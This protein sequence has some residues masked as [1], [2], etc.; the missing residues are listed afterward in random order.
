MSKLAKA[1]TAAAG[2]AGVAD[3]PNVADVFSTYLYEGTGSGNANT[4]TNG[5]DLD[6]EGGMVW[7][8]GRDYGIGNNCLFD[9]ERGVNKVLY[10]NS[11]SA[12]GSG[13]SL[14]SFT[15]S[16]FVAQYTNDI[17]EN[18]RSL[19]SW[20]FR[21]APR[22][23]DVVTYTGDGVTGREIAHDLGCDVG[24]IFIKLR[25]ELSGN[26]GSWRT[27]HKSL[28]GTQ[29]LLLE[30]TAAASTW[31]GIFNDTDATDSVFTVTGHTHVNALGGEYVAY[32]FAHDPDGENDDGMIACGSFVPSSTWGSEI[33]IGWEPQYVMFKKTTGTGDWNIHDSMRGIISGSADP[34]LW[35]NKSDAEAGY[36]DNIEITA[37]GF[38][39]V[40]SSVDTNTYIYMAIRAPMM[41]EPESGTDVFKA[42][43]FTASTTIFTPNFPP[44]LNIQ[45]GVRTSGG[46]IYT[47][48][49]LTGDGK[50]LQTASTSAEGSYSSYR[51]GLATGTFKQSLYSGT[52]SGGLELMFKRAKG[53]MDVVA[54]SGNGTAGRTVN[55]SL[56]VVPEM[57]IIKNRDQ[58]R[59]WAVYNKDIGNNYRLELNS[60][61]NKLISSEW[62]TTTPTS[63]LFTLG[64]DGEVNS[65][66][67]ND[68][69]AY[70]F[71]TL[72]G[73]SKVGSYTGNG[74]NQNIA[75]GFSGGA[76][77]V[78][79]KRTDSSGDWYMWDTTRGIVTGND[80]HLSLNT[81]SAEVTSDD[82]ID[83]QST[84]FTVNQVAATNINV[85]SATYIFLA[86]A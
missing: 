83:P 85:T 30:D 64:S 18:G 77:F 66:L 54:Y 5:I 8:K 11:T 59:Y 82:S 55:H 49:R 86:I 56:G 41:V 67:G 9:T 44:D 42:E 73:V 22:F 71:A 81:T 74:T 58:T 19:S 68:Y 15:S 1:L 43:L 25:H 75:C 4:I 12:E 48:S 60:T 33:S 79:I 13:A 34:K 39:Q 28:G 53:F 32:L 2:N 38:K 78:M 21:K 31:S 72:A 7:I 50:Y 52:S 45:K 62:N 63:N 70:L 57:M 61:T 16:G 69:I 14:T 47:G 36:S 51:Y 40:F 46:G 26:T 24:M 10:S 35:A 80:P 27:Y 17:N 3:A 37:N 23:F 84:G 76:R 20:T 29:Y 6:G 65:S